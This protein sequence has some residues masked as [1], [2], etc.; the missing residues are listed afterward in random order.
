MSFFRI[1]RRVEVGVHNTG[2]RLYYRHAGRVAYKVYQLASAARYA[3]VDISYGRQHGCRGFVSGRKKRDRRRVYSMTG[4]HLM[5]HIDRGTVGTVG[6]ASAFQHTCI[7]AFET[8]RENVECYV[9]PCLIYHADHTE[10]HTHAPQSQTVVKRTLCQGAAQRR[11]QPAHIAHVCGYRLQPAFRKHQPV[12]K[13]IRRFH[14]FQV[15]NVGLQYVAL[16]GY[17]RIGHITQYP[18]TLFIGQQCEFPAGRLG[19]LE[20]LCHWYMFMFSF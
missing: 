9:W 20:C 15:C 11:R 4:K 19:F 7:A 10:R 8:K 12:V 6:I 2:A 14:L 3:K 13:R 16:T 5:Y 18:V 17:Y 1:S